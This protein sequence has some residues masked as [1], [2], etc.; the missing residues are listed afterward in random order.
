[1]EAC[2]VC[3][4]HIDGGLEPVPDGG[5]EWVGEAKIARERALSLKPLLQQI[6]P[7]LICPVCWGAAAGILQRLIPGRTSR[8][9]FFDL[10]SQPAIPAALAALEDSPLWRV[11][12][13]TEKAPGVIEV[14]AFDYRG[15]PLTPRQVKLMAEPLEKR[16]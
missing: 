12:L 3:G 6:T 7:S 5:H 2:G 10:R 16:P 14:E 11:A 15:K 9:M 13:L 4:V 1:M 8:S